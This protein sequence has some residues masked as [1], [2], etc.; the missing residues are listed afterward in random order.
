[1]DKFKKAYSRGCRG[2]GNPTCRYCGDFT[3]KDK[4]ILRRLGRRRLKAA[5]RAEIKDKY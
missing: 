4:K 2:C 3:K 1:M 5:A